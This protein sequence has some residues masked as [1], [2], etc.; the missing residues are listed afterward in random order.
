MNL[1]KLLCVFL[2]AS[3]MM[4][5]YSCEDEFN[6]DDNLTNIDS[7]S[8]R[9]PSKD[10]YIF[11]SLEEYKQILAEFND[12]TDEKIERWEQKESFIS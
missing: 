5:M 8:Y 1:L 3:L 10:M 7:E 6:S 11:S 2:V 12:I 9:G 4:L